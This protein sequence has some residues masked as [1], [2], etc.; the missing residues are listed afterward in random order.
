MHRKNGCNVLCWAGLP[1]TFLLF[2]GLALA[3]AQEPIPAQPT[4]AQ[5]TPA[6]A[7]ALIVPING[8][9][10]L[11]MS[12][13]QKI[14]TV[15]NPKENAVSLRTLAGDPTTILV[16]GQQPDVTRIELEDTEGNKE[17]YEVIVQADIEYLRT[18]LRRAVPTANVTTIPI[19]SNTVI[20]SGTVTRAEDV[21]I[22]R[23]L[24]NSV[25][26][27]FIDGMRVGGVQQVQLDVIVVQVSR[28]DLRSLAFNFLGDSRYGFGGSTVANAASQ[29]TAL[30]GSGGAFSTGSGNFITA[31]G[32]PNGTPTNLLFGLLH[33][34]WGFHNYL[35]ALKQ[36]N[37]AKLLAEPRLVTLSGRP[38][39]FLVGGEQA[40]PVPAG[41]GQIGVQFEEFG[42][43]LNFIPI[44]LGNGRI[45]LEVEPEVSN[46]NAAAGVSINGTTVPGRSTNRVNT[47]VELESGQTFVIGG[48]IQ[49][50]VQNTVSKVPCLGD[51]PCLGVFFRSVSAQDTEEEVLVIV[52]PWLVDPESCNQ[53]PKILPGEE[54][55]QPDD[56]ELFLEGIIEAPRGARQAHQHLHHVPAWMNSP[57]AALFPCASKGNCAVG[58]CGAGACGAGGS[59]GQVGGDA[60][61]GA[62]VVNPAAPSPLP[63]GL[64]PAPMQ[65]SAGPVNAAPLAP[66]SG[67]Q[68]QTTPPP[69]APIRPVPQGGEVYSPAA[70]SDLSAKMPER[71]SR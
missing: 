14:R 3:P 70:M 52:T 49:H 53:R 4:P 42:T 61:L 26:F 21:A 35:E 31:P 71:G 54:T 34:S 2:V 57:S 23:G 28:S 55:R 63:A 33:N 41:L 48:L 8:T 37:L 56:F 36:N 22:I 43:R 65:N 32:S 44:V 59:A 46:L 47:T 10:K 25:G 20:L 18:Q 1:I 51:L 66:A 67:T 15:T 27:K 38:A 16:I 24:V 50:Q 39:S 12:K 40:I 64:A 5:P 30:G 9:V 7:N 58:G 68:I 62:A 17:V 29:P 69:E 13:K 11:Q 19:S 45:H 6:Q 60:P